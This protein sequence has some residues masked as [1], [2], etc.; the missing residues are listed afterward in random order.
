MS[1]KRNNV[2]VPYA[3]GDY[4]QKNNDAMSIDDKEQDSKL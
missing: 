3:G 1:Y 2:N 4:A